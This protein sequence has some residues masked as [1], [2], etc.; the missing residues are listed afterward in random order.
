MKEKVE[1]ADQDN[2]D[3]DNDEKD[4]NDNLSNDEDKSCA[5]C[6]GD[7]DDEDLVLLN[8]CGHRYHTYCLY[9][10]LQADISIYHSYP[11]CSVCEV[12]GKETIISTDICRNVIETQN[13]SDLLVEYEKLLKQKTATVQNEW[14]SCFEK[15]YTEYKYFD[16]CVYLY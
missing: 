3:V 14:T 1:G 16:F 7:I 9:Q 2:E 12:D 5:L 13:D 4:D 8:E 6:F 11:K 10:S 15:K